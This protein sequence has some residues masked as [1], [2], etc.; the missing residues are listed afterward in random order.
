MDKDTWQLVLT[1]QPDVIEDTEQIG[2]ELLESLYEDDTIMSGFFTED[3]ADSTVIT[4]VTE[5]TALDGDSDDISDMTDIQVMLL[6]ENMSAFGNDDQV[7]DS[8]NFGDITVD[9][10]SLDRLLVNT[11]I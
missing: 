3:S 1:K 6:A 11:P 10:T 8:M 9:T 4:D 7:Y 2:A 5:S